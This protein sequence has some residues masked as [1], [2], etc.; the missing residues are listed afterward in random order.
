MGSSGKR[1]LLIN[2]WIYD[3]AAYD[4]WAKPLGLLMLGSHLRDRGHRVF[5]VDCVDVHSPW[6]AG[7]NV[8]R[9]ARKP[10]HCGKL[11]KEPVEKPQALESIPRAYSRYGITEKAFYRALKKIGRPDLVLVTS[12]MTYWYPGPFRVI[13]I[14]KTAFP[15]VPAVLGGVYATLCREHAAVNGG[16]DYVLPGRAVDPLLARIDGIL[17]TRT[18]KTEKTLYPAMDLYSHLDSVPLFTSRGCPKRCA[19]CACLYLENEFKQRSPEAVIDEIVH[20][21]EGYGVRDI[22]FY[23]DALLV[24]AWD[25]LIPILEDILE[26]R[27]VC[28][29]HLPNGI[30]ARDLTPKVADLMFRTG[31]RTIRLGLETVN[32]AKQLET[33]GKVT[34]GE[35]L[36]AIDTLR[37]VGYSQKQ[38]GVYLMAGL[39]GQ[40]WE[41]VEAGIEKVFEWGGL[42]KIAEFSPIP[43][44]AL[45]SEA[46]RFSSYDIEREPLFQNNSILPCQWEGFTT[47]DLTSIKTRLQHRLREFI[48]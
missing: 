13:E 26:R 29:F 42:P 22:A 5:F 2:P 1:I 19:Y 11:F 4:L 20:W 17:D 38:I 47:D 39:P 45:W 25:H 27:L 48:P 30:H 12:H 31:F 18:E 28:R 44:T 14:V 3:F 23:D 21:V 7:E 9:P 15:D 16:A 40:P 6:M 32:P 36:Q 10:Y 24:N 43:H 33:G 8:T 46:L 41:E 37:G 35:V 34:D